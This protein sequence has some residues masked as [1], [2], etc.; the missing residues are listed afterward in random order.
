MRSGSPPETISVALCTYNGARFL[1]E[2]LASLQAQIRCPD[3][4]IV[5]DDRSTDKTVQLLEA[6]ARIAP[7]PVRIHVNPANLGSTMNF[8]RA[9]RL[10]TGSLI[11]FCDQ[12]DIWHSTRLS[13]CAEAFQHDP[14]LELVFSNGQ[15]IDEAGTQIPGR[16][17]DKFTF[18]PA[19]RKRIQH[20]DMLPLV[21]YRFVTG[22]TVMFRSHLREYVCPAAGEW[23]HDGWIAAFAACLGGVGFLDEPLIRYRIHPQQQIGTGP[24]PTGRAFGK[25]AREHWLGSD[26]HRHQIELLLDCL[27]KIP[28]PLRTATAD[29]FNRQHAFLSMRITLPGHRWP[30][31]SKIAGFRADYKRRASGW[32]SMLLDFLLPKRDDET[33]SAATAHFSALRSR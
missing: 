13:A 1:E 33:G 19:I 20:G 12:D 23:L 24:G 16:L 26:W 31:V 2:Q 9:M 21:R 11:A 22:A 14:R 8:D 25:L 30:R 5:C 18:D 3:E 28:V 7:F 4:L 15:L 27:R 32:K 17:W 10:C 29:D 6:F